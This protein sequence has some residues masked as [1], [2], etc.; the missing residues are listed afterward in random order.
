MSKMYQDDEWEQAWRAK[1][2]N[3][4]VREMPASCDELIRLVL[5]AYSANRRA[6]MSQKERN[7][8]ALRKS[9]RERKK[10]REDPEFR[11]KSLA[12]S[13]AWR[14]K[15]QQENKDEPIS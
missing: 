15:K 10:W 9:E 11:R 3:L 12:R 13:K 4:E 8:Q 7:Q 2:P 5:F 14:L 1:F 6:G